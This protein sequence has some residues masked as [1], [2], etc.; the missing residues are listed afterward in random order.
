R[1]GWLFSGDIGKIDS[2]GY[3]FIVGRKKEMIISGGENIY[4][5][6]I[7]NALLNHPLIA[8]AAVV[9][10]PDE[11]WGEVPIAFI[12]CTG[13]FSESELVA[14]LKKTIGSYKTPKKFILKTNLPRN[15]AGKVLKNELKNGS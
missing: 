3:L 11:K 2:D 12:V 7:E 15:Q 5:A 14:F 10:I 4:P 9:G 8:E 1:D 13:K 6:E